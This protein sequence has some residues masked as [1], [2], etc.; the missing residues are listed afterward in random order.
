[1][2]PTTSAPRP[3]DAASVRQR[4]WLLFAMVVVALLLRMPLLGRSI[5]FDEACMSDQR[6]GTWPQL[7]ATLYVDI[8]PPLYLVF[9]HVWNGLFGD[10]EL[11]MRIP[12]LVAGLAC[13]PLTFWTGSRLV[14]ERGALWAALLLTLSPAHIWYSAEAR[15][16]SPMVACALLSFGTFDRLLDP[17]L[18]PRRGLFALHVANVAVMLALHYYLAVFV[19]AQAVLAPVVA[20][21]FTRP[22]RR[23]LI[24]HGVGILLLGA[25]VF[26]K[27][28]LGEFETSQDYLRA[29]GVGELARFL[30]VWCWTGDTLAPT[31]APLALA[32]ASVHRWLGAAL[33]AAGLV[34]VL[35]RTASRPRSL[36][37]LVALGA[38]PAF[39]FVLTAV[40]YDRTYLERTMIAALPFVLLLAGAGVAL[41]PG[42][43]APPA[44]SATAFAIAALVGLYANLDTH[45]T[46]YKPNSDWRGAAAWLGREIDAGGSGRPVFTST[47]NPRSL[48]YYDVRI[49]DA[50]NLAPPAAPEAIGRAVGRRL[51]GAIG[52]Y[53]ERT[54]RAFEAHNA[55]L[56]AG[57]K[58][59][60][61][62][63]AP[64]PAQL[65]L[66]ADRPDDVCYLVRDHWHP[67]VSVDGSVEALL[68][69]PD[70]KLLEEQRFVGISVYKVRIAK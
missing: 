47:P 40:G 2:E 63:S 62:R 30:T 50:K 70:V 29:F 58:L 15:L 22:A 56:L 48:S 57:A 53:A 3:D 44:A 26:V 69:H 19:V 25:F 20:R 66:P 46:V 14:G 34:H 10:G 61:R 37:L 28:S 35:R 4:G 68:Q 8:H 51:G 42:R 32:T 60:V 1:M 45:W 52:A 67:H 43:L 64:T 7:L 38:L 54:F 49:Q 41:F 11:S 23:I 18:P 17:D 65:E 31:G 24:A 27:S 9:M 33:L 13:I 39:L 59:I 55:E 21:G 12:P 36:L 5:W 16:Y 6:I